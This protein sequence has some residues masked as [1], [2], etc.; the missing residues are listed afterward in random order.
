[1]SQ[2]WSATGRPSIS[3]CSVRKS[4]PIVERLAS[5]YASSTK[6]EMSDVLPTPA[7]PTQ[8][9]L[10]V[11]L[12]VPPSVGRGSSEGLSFCLASVATSHSSREYS[13]PDA[14]STIP[15]ARWSELESAALAL[16][17]SSDAPAYGRNESPLIVLCSQRSCVLSRT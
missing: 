5:A 4:I 16:W 11:V 7:S 8:R 1:V 15:S 17:P 2:S 3:S 6:R 13:T 14:D 12:Y 10:N 9:S